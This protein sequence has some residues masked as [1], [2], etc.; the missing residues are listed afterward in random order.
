MVNTITLSCI[1]EDLFD[2]LNTIKSQ[3]NYSKKRSHFENKLHM[4]NDT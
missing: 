4:I 2:K 3:L 1:D